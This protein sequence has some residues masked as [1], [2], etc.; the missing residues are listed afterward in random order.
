MVTSTTV[1]FVRF[2]SFCLSF[3]LNPLHSKRISHVC[4]LSLSAS[5]SL[6]L[7]LSLSPLEFANCNRG[8]PVQGLF[9]FNLKIS[10]VEKDR[11]QSALR[12]SWNLA[13]DQPGNQERRG[14]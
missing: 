2:L 9:S 7:S 14:C 8:V 1:S 6:S 11:H 12:S 13:D 10:A 3:S 4:T 5:L